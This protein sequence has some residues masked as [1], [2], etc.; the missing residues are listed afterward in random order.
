[1][2][3]DNLVCTIL[4]STQQHLKKKKATHN[5]KRSVPVGVSL[6]IWDTRLSTTPPWRIAKMCVCVCISVCVCVCACLLACLP[7]CLPPCMCVST[8]SSA[9]YH[10]FCEYVFYIIDTNIGYMLVFF[11][12]LNVP[13]LYLSSALANNPCT[14]RVCTTSLLPYHMIAMAL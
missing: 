10:T 11:A 14:K 3:S 4:C 5:M 7:A 13:C 12:A 9:P 2:V 1:M 8:I 6:V